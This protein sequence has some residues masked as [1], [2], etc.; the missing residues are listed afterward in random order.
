VAHIARALKEVVEAIMDLCERLRRWLG[1]YPDR[2]ED[3][4]LKRTTD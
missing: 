1:V 3:P 2:C 4:S